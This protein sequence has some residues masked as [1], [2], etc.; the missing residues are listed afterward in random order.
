MGYSRRDRRKLERYFVIAAAVAATLS[1]STS[2]PAADKTFTGAGTPANSWNVPANWSPVG[3]PGPSDRVFLDTAS[4]T[5]GAY[6][7]SILTLDYSPTVLSLNLNNN[8]NGTAFSPGPVRLEASASGTTAQVLTLTGDTSSTPVPILGVGDTSA[9][10]SAATAS[11]SA[12]Y[13]QLQGPAT[14][15]SSGASTASTPGGSLTLNLSSSGSFSVVAPA[16]NSTPLASLPVVPIAL[17]GSSL[18]IMSTL[19][20]LGGN[21]TIIKTGAGNLFLGGINTFGGGAGQSV[22]V[23]GGKLGIVNDNALGALSNGLVLDGGTLVLGDNTTFN[24]AISITNNGGTLETN[25]NVTAIFEGVG[26]SGT[27]VNGITAGST[28]AT[29]IK[30]GV[31]TLDIVTPVSYSGAVLLA[32]NGGTLAV[33]ASGFNSAAT[34]GSIANAA[35]ITISPG[36]TLLDDNFSSVAGFIGFRNNNNTTPAGPTPV[37]TDRIGNSIP[38]ILNGGTFT[39]NAGTF[40]NNATPTPMITETLGTVTLNQGLS[41]ITSTRNGQGAE[42]AITT[43]NRGGI[44]TAVNFTGTTLGATGDTS[45]IFI[46]AL[47]NGGTSVALPT[48]A[49]TGSGQML[50]GWAVANA[51]GPAL[52]VPPVTAANPLSDVGGVGQAGN[53]GPTGD[54]YAAYTTTFAPGNLTSISATTAIGS[55]ETGAM[56]IA[57]AF[58]LTFTTNTNSLNIDSGGFYFDNTNMHE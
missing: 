58:N 1:G 27:V 25:R 44:G 53:T 32:Q 40:Q 37:N 9:T 55:S 57:G 2:A 11:S 5:S 10:A 46:N 35:S 43:L 29:F 23:S 34:T 17:P 15:Y 51:D 19:Q 24:R 42:I 3:Q 13:L 56:R 18:T 49:A 26:P 6:V 14:S 50:G 33:T 38:L 8:P 36:A 48:A 12:G 41:T 45:R 52:Y 21:F 39:Y 7:P 4:L 54:N 47:Q 28:A 30:S 22:T 20:N 16:P 31:G